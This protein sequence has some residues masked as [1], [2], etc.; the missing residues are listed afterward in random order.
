[1]KYENVYG[2]VHD[3]IRRVHKKTEPVLELNGMLD[4]VKTVL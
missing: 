2:G 3:D 1:M 4:L